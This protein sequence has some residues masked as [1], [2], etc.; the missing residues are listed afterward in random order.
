MSERLSA[1]HGCHQIMSVS[2]PVGLEFDPK[3]LSF[4]DCPELSCAL[5]W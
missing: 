5:A 2:H 1:T 4:D 3:W